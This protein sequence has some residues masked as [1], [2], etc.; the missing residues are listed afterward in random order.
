MAAGNCAVI[1]RPNWPAHIGGGG[2][3]HPRETSRKNTS[4]SARASATRP[5]PASRAIRHDFSSPAARRSRIVHG[6]PAA[7]HLTPVT[8]ELGGK[9]PCV[10]CADAPI[11]VTARR[12]IWGKF[13]NARA[14]VRRSRFPAGGSSRCARFGGGDEGGVA[15]FYGDHP[16]RRARD[17]G[18]S[19]TAGTSTAW[20]GCLPV[21]ALSMVDNRTRTIS[22]SRR[23]S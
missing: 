7:Q 10:V 4:P 20:S 5:R 21:D 15:Q 6:R 3:T 8:L 12:I 11:E 9:C 19:S 18:R 16:R 14:N 17:Y 22:T 13:M 2:Q 1:K 23:P